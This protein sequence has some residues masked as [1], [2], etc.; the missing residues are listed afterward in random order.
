MSLLGS[1]DTI[2]TGESPSEACVCGRVQ[3]SRREAS[4]IRTLHA[5][6]AGLR[7]L[8]TW[9]LVGLVFAK[10]C[11]RFQAAQ[12]RMVDQICGFYLLWRPAYWCSTLL[13]L[14]ESIQNFARA[15]QEWQPWRYADY[16]L[17]VPA[18]TSP[19]KLCLESGGVFI[20]RKTIFT[21][22]NHE[23]A[24]RRKLTP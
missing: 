23:H 6:L 15:R 11:P 4:H 21:M 14:P 22:F 5:S 3:K 7:A 24:Q 10:M 20:I 12:N 13:L 9:N 19:I 16:D 17:T 2:T 8:A 18:Y 1:N